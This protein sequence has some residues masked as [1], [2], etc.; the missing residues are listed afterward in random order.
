MLRMSREDY[1][2]N[3]DLIFKELDPKKIYDELVL[4]GGAD[5]ILLCWEKP[6]TW[7]HRRRIAEWLEEALGIEITEYGYNRADVL[8]YHPGPRPPPPVNPQL[9]LF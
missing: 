8:P 5:P 7:C 9:E 1:D 3:F 2:L 4:M 6:N